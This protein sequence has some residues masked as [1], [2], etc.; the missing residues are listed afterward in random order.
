MVI[1]PFF[2]VFYLITV[3][4]CTVRSI[5]AESID[6]GDWKSFS[7]DAV[8]DRIIL[9]LPDYQRDLFAD[10][11]LANQGSF[12]A[13]PDANLAVAGSGSTASGGLR[14][15]LAPLLDT[16]SVISDTG[17]TAQETKEGLFADLNI[18]SN[19]ADTA[20][21]PE[22]QGRQLD[23]SIITSS[24]LGT[25]VTA[26]IDKGQIV[27]STSEL[28]A[29]VPGCGTGQSDQE[30]QLSCPLNLN[31]GTKRRKKPDLDRPSEFVEPSQDEI[32]NK[33][34]YGE[35]NPWILGLDGTW[36]RCSNS[37]Y[38]LCCDGPS[39]LIQWVSNCYD[40][41]CSYLPCY[42]YTPLLPPSNSHPRL[43]FWFYDRVR[44]LA[45]RNLL[46]DPT[47]NI[48]LQESWRKSLLLL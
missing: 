40:C 17:P 29:A 10:S 4:V 3:H 36:K 46:F 20:I 41:S 14:P 22:D 35:P 5:D 28:E 21:V 26:P 25:D 42:P 23:S 1:F 33:V 47:Q 13:N 31:Q 48:L 45:S 39:H 27:P 18:A 24:K 9:G 30:K 12:L 6:S 34:E 43:T 32:D 19:A 44:E 16:S 8:T 15:L 11:N 7:F 38:T 37:K 2:L